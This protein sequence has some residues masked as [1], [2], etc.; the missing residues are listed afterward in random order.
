MI[1]I[2]LNHSE[3][4]ALL[5]TMALRDVEIRAVQQ[6]Y[7]PDVNAIAEDI[8]KRAGHDVAAY[9]WTNTPDCMKLTG[10]PKAEPKNETKNVKGRKR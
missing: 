8:I 10:E 7:A 1:E 2:E 9:N 3:R 6:K 5:A 4:V